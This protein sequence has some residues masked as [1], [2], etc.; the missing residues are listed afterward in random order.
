[1]E[2]EKEICKNYAYIINKRVQGGVYFHSHLAGHKV[3]AG[4]QIEPVTHSYIK[5]LF[6]EQFTPATPATHFWTRY[7]MGVPEELCFMVRK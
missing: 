3:G 6:D 7:A 1:M 4:N 2:M 5:Q